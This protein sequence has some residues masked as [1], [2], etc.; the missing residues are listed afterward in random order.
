MPLSVDLRRRVLEVIDEGMTIKEA[1]ASF[2]VCQRAVCNWLKLRKETGSLEP[3]IG[4]QKGHSHKIKDWDLFK[5]FIQKY[6]GL[7]SPYLI[8]EWEKL[9]QVKMSESVML[10][11]LKKIGYS[12]KKKHLSTSNQMKKN[13]KNF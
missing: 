13:E 6:Q 4:Y 1:A 12:F 8:I 9:T 7:T 5:E 3:K 11:A 2:K 10:R